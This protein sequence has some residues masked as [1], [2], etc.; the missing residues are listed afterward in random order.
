MKY[1]F[2]NHTV[3]IWT[4]SGKTYAHQVANMLSRKYGGSF[5]DVFSKEDAVA[6]T[7]I[8]G[9][10]G[11][12]M[13]YLWTRGYSPHN[14]V[15]VDDAEYNYNVPTTRK[16]MIKVKPF[17]MKADDTE[18]LRVLS[19]LKRKGRSKRSSLHKRKGFTRRTGLRF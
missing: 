5:K 10:N 19:I 7:K 9:Y 1:L 2:K 14:T 11:K 12:D 15:L 3:S 4:W 8:H 13:D 16:H 18:L 6:S 17:Q